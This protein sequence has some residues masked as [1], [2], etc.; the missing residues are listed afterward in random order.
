[1]GSNDYVPMRLRKSKVERNQILTKLLKIMEDICQP[2]VVIWECRDHR[3]RV[4][5]SNVKQSYLNRPLV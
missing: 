4:T 2:F 3:L 1:M 5:I